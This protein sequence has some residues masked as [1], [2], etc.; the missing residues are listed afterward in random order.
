MIFEV[1]K[2]ESEL[3]Y[4]RHIK[5]NEHVMGNYP[6][7]E[8]KEQADIYAQLL[9]VSPFIWDFSTFDEMVLMNDRD[10]LIDFA[11]DAH[12]MAKALA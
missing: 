3:W 1:F 7:F 2:H 6:G 5:S 9:D 4:V 12:T 8:K 10:Q 11:G